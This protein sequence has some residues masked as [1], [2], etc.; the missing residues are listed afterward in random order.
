M[1]RIVVLLA[2]IF[3]LALP[4]SFAQT[5]GSSSRRTIPKATAVA[6]ATPP[7]RKPSFFE[8]LFGRRPRPTQAPATPTP[9]SKPR[10]TKPTTTR[11]PVARTTSRPK[12]KPASTAADATGKPAATTTDA[13]VEKP[14]PKPAAPRTTTRQTTSKPA[15]TAKVAPPPPGTTDLEE[16]D[17]QKYDAARV[18]AMEDP[19]IQALKQKADEAVSDAEANQAQRAYN[20]ALFAKMRK[21]DPL[22]KERIDRMESAVM[23]KLSDQ[24][25]AR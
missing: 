10:I 25:G 2:V 8:R 21:L 22:I 17:K 1:F 24:P 19:E 5:T 23:K 11:R 9:T 14:A 3:G 4:H 13:T 6:E 7:P 18:K 15:A 20:K 12:S 16:L